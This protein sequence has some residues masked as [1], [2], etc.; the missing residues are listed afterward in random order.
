MLKKNS[1]L[2]QKLRGLFQQSMTGDAVAY[3]SFLV[4]VS[5]IVRR[6]LVVLGGRGLSHEQMEELQQEVV[7]SIHQKKHTYS[8]ERPLLPWIYAVARYRYI[9]DYRQ[10]KRLPTAVEWVDELGTEEE[11]A[12]EPLDYEELLAL[13]TPQQRELFVRIKIEGQTYVQTAQA[14]EL[15][16]PAVK[17]GVHR[18]MKVLKDKVQR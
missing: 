4:L 1:E 9:D 10:K 5:G 7:L 15:S 16:V 6:N 13:L 14:L 12:N 17:V 3:E 11:A 18:I 2:E 8:L